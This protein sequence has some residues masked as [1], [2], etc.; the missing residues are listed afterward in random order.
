MTMFLKH[1]T[2]YI[3]MVYQNVKDFYH[4]IIGLGSLFKVALILGLLSRKLCL[5]EKYKVCLSLPDLP[6]YPTL[7]LSP[8]HHSKQ[9][10]AL[11]YISIK[12]RAVDT[13]GR[14]VH[15]P[16]TFLQG[17]EIFNYHFCSFVRFS[18]LDPHF[19]YHVDGPEDLWELFYHFIATSISLCLIVD[20]YEDLWELYQHSPSNQLP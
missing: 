20:I 4:F 7:T 9:S 18:I 5:S 14:G 2:L 11:N 17:N 8:Y 19:W 10:I 1:K 12:I 6:L 15:G 16:P 3:A 13:G